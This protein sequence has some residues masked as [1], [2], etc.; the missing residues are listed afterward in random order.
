MRFQSNNSIK[1]SITTGGCC[2]IYKIYI[3]LLEVV[4]Y[5]E[6]GVFKNRIVP[7]FHTPPSSETTMRQLGWS[8]LPVGVGGLCAS[9]EPHGVSNNVS[10]WE[11]VVLHWDCASAGWRDG[12]VMVLR[13]VTCAS[14]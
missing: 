11:A 3:C 14:P 9:T 7:M 8:K 13:G 5:F 2:A 6:S 4:C 1:Q 12:I 10:R